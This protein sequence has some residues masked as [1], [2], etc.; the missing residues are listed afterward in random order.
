MGICHNLINFH[1]TKKE[2]GTSVSLFNSQIIVDNKIL[3]PVKF[4]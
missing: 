2:A 1:E 3:Q 4:Y